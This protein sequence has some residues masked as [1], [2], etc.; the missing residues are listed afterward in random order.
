[1]RYF[2]AKTEPLVYSIDQFAK[3]HKTVWDGIKNPQ[4]LRA[5]R[6]MKPGDRVLIYHSGGESQI[7]GLAKVVSEATEDPKDP[8]SAVVDLEFMRR[9]EN[10]VTLRAIK[11]S[12]LF[13]DFALVKQSR[14]STMEVPTEF[15]EWLKGQMPKGSL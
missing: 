11:E 3:D 15:I 14:L 10:P 2:L 8:K 9:F 13:A 7:V 1:V 12:G 6:N 5:V 4:A